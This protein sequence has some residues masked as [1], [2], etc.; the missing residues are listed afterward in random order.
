MKN[1]PLRHFC[2]ASRVV[3]PPLKNRRS[4][5]AGDGRFQAFA[6]FPFRC[7]P[8]PG[9]RGQGFDLVTAADQLGNF[10]A[11]PSNIAL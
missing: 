11:L 8:S 2:S 4:F 3:D 1:A 10:S 5:L 9:P 6:G 7:G